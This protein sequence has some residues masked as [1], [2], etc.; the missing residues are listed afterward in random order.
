[1]MIADAQVHIWAPDRPERPWR[2]GQEPHRAKPLEADELLREMDAAGVDRA[3]LISPYWDGPRNDVVLAAARAHP[4]RFAAMG[5]LDND[6]P[7]QPGQLRT[8]RSTPGML[9]LR[10]S[11][12]RRQ[13]GATLSGLDW[14]WSEAE[15]GG[16]PLMLLVPHSQAHL[17]GE[18][19]ARHPKLKLIMSHMGL[20]SGQKDDEAFRELDKLIALAKYPN[21][22][23]K[24]SALPTYTSDAYPYR[25]LHPY[26]RRVYDAFAQSACSGAPISRGCPAP[27]GSPSRCSP[28]KSRGSRRRTRRG[29]WAAA[30]ASGSTGS[31]LPIHTLL[32]AHRPTLQGT[33][34]WQ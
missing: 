30:F 24:V 14:V 3:I 8:W 13:E 9:G 21:I 2:K 10:C 1:M 12:S 4:D 20:T 31:N 27:T 23:V 18:I 16:V 29:S 11:F 32:R 26:L 33:P 25:A 34:T 6:P 22:A 19:A 15:E 7:P 28:R 17:V 5:R